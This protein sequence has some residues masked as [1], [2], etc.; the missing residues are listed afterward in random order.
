MRISP[1]RLTE[2]QV[3]ASFKAAHGNTY[4]YSLF[5][6]TR[7]R[8]KGTIICKA[9]GTFEQAP[10]VHRIGVG[11]PQCGDE[12]AAR[13]KLLALDTV[14]IK[15]N[16]I[17]NWKYDYSK[18]G[19]YRGGKQKYI[20]ICPIHGE[21]TQPLAAHSNGAGCRLCADNTLSANKLLTTDEVVL[22]FKAV[23]GTKYGYDLVNYTGDINNVTI[24]CKEH[25]SFVQTPSNHKRGKGCA[26]CASNGFNS[27]QPALLYYLRVTKGGTVA[28]K[29]GITNRTV[30][31]RFGTD[32]QYIKILKVWE[33]EVGADAYSA[34]QNILKLNAEYR[35]TGEPLLRSGNTELFNADVGELD[36]E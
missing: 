6:F 36:N 27:M 31:E 32:M 33:Y 26:H 7:S 9:H 17:H 11:C 20:I 8:D 35:Y 25:G 23:H 16:A 12:A 13:K 3:L 22:Q 29:I 15:S 24:V 19:T 34:E 10:T 5:K 21:F 4:D 2:A 1:S 14:I 28:Y 30:E 18:I